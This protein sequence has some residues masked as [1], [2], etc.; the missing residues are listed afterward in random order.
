MVDRKGAFK[1][2]S[3]LVPFSLLDVCL[4]LRLRVCREEVDMSKDHRKCHT[5][6][7]FETNNVKIE[8]VLDDLQKHLNNYEIGDFCRL[9]IL[10]DLSKFFFCKKREGKCKLRY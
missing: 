9:Y 6:Q 8:N 1:I 4:R 7:L 2:R 3:V 10:L 5:R